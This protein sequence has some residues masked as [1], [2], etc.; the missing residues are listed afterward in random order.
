MPKRTL[1]ELAATAL[2][3]G[4]APDT[5]ALAVAAATQPQQQIIAGT[6]ADIARKLE[7]ASPEGPVLVMIGRALADAAQAG[8]AEGA[9]AAPTQE[10]RVSVQ[11]V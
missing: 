1:A 11:G 6:I 4:L 9:D 10:S 2:A 7:D 8:T 3:H 5:P